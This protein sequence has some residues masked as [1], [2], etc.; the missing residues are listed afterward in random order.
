MATMAFFN[1]LSVE[2]ISLQQIPIGCNETDATHGE[3]TQY[4][5]TGW[6]RGL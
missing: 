3:G 2:T 4:A 5:A 1:S 6:C